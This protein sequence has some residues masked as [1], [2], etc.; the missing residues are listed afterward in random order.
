MGMKLSYGKTID[1][2]HVSNRVIMRIF[3][4]T[5]EEVT[6]EWGKLRNKKLHN[7][8]SSLYVSKVII[9]R[10]LD[11][12]VGT[13]TG[14]G[15]DG[16]GVEVR[17]LVG[18]GFFSS[19]SRPDRFWCPPSLLTNEYQGSLFPGVKRPR[20]EAHHSPPTSAEVKNTW[21]YTSNTPY[22]FMA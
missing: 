3:E 13:A 19:P 4:P 10:S 9:L 17:V 6:R 5:R 11:S 1:W 22:V 15:L 20:R 7:L 21:I 16:L 8:H 12:T 18:T 14:Y 2:G